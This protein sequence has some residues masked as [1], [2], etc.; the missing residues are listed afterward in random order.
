M[1]GLSGQ[2]SS[3][4]PLG[5][6]SITQKQ[7]Q[8]GGASHGPSSSHSGGCR[9]NASGSGSSNGGGAGVAAGD[10]GSAARL[11]GTKASGGCGA[12]GTYAPGAHLTNTELR[13]PSAKPVVAKT[14][15]GLQPMDESMARVTSDAAGVKLTPRAN[16]AEKRN[17]ARKLQ[18]AYRRRRWRV[19]LQ[20]VGKGAGGCFCGNKAYRPLLDPYG[21]VHGVRGPSGRWYVGRSLGC[22]SPLNPIRTL[23]ILLIEASWFDNVIL[24]TILANCVILALSDRPPDS[25]LYISP[26]ITEQLELIFV[27]TF[28]GELACKAVAMGIF[29][30]PYHALLSDRWNQL[31]L[32]VVI[33]AWLPL[34]FPSLDGYTSL[35]ALRAFRP[36]RAAHMLPGV[37]RQVNTLIKALPPL[38][39]VAILILF[40]SMSFGILGMQVSACTLLP[41][42]ERACHPSSSP[43]HVGLSSP[44]ALAPPLSHRSLFFSRHSRHSPPSSHHPVRSLQ[45]FKG[46]LHHRCYAEETL[47]AAGFD[48]ASI[49]PGSPAPAGVL[50]IDAQGGVCNP[51]MSRA[52]S[53]ALLGQISAH[54]ATGDTTGADRHARGGCVD[55]LCLE[56]GESPKHGTISFD[57]FPSAL[58]TVF[59]CITGEGWTEVMY[60]TM[61]GYHSSAFVYFV[62]LTL[63]GSFYIVNLFLAVL[64]ETYSSLPKELT[65]EEQVA[66]AKWKAEHAG[67]EDDEEPLVGAGAR[68]KWQLNL[69]RFRRYKSSEENLTDALSCRSRMRKLVLSNSFRL[70]I[71]AL[72]LANTGLMMLESH[73]QPDY[74]RD[75]I[76][77]G[78]LVFFC[79]YAVE[80]VVKLFALGPG[81]YWAEE[82]NRFDGAIV[83]VSGAEVR[84]RWGRRRG[85]RGPLSSKRQDEEG[86]G[87]ALGRRPLVALTELNPSA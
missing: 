55:G 11:S 16:L 68:V 34:V 74:Q 25:L 61:H 27:W 57:S 84:S 77:V 82:F 75:V 51:E 10:F 65:P 23:F 79:C 35:R 58:M 71:M 48:P 22:L 41:C 60:M 56:F 37:R 13:L 17:A 19:L 62:V 64:W 76:E 39:N 78:N 69:P 72:I 80:M 70:Q 38:A 20:S 4:L 83:L 8:Q 30:D 3:S 67:E 12:A 26:S 49:I 47:R 5:C 52:L 1:K 43:P 2:K 66:H 81:D 7:A 24:L 40:I 9:G 36:L 29:T 46:Q 86:G 42:G 53:T 18:S 21:H 28:S 73:P 59:M 45:L 32:A 54:T 6:A 50:P 14:N 15:L 85:G 44:L 31:D 63:V 33:S 87:C